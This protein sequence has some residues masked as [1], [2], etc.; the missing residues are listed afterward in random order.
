MKTEML[1]V[2][3]PQNCGPCLEPSAVGSAAK[4][5]SQSLEGDH[6]YSGSSDFWKILPE[7]AKMFLSETHFCLLTL[8]PLKTLKIAKTN[9]RCLCCGLLS[10][11]WLTSVSAP[12][13]TA[14]CSRALQ[15]GA[16]G[17]LWAFAGESHSWAALLWQELILPR[18][19]S[20]FRWISGR[21]SALFKEKCYRW[22]DEE[23][24]LP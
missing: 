12:R 4:P 2:G 23:S 3:R 24:H 22:K 21:N 1:S 7:W 9:D 14:F 11:K 13:Q 20:Q 8:L 19:V 5:L 18:T 16:L 6:L 10:F 17:V 15:A